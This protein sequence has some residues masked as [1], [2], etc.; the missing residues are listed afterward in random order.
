ME[1]TDAKKLHAVQVGDTLH[2]F[3]DENAPALRK[4]IE[5]AMRRG[6]AAVHVS[7][8]GWSEW[9]DVVAITDTAKDG[10]TVYTWDAGGDR[11]KCDRYHCILRDGEVTRTHIGTSYRDFLKL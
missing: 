7:E 4:K 11:V 3:D 6:H 10:S 5:A 2:I 1:L 8:G 9:Y